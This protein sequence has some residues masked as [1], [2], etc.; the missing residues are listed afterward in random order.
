MD[1]SLIERR[2]ARGNYY[3]T[4]DIFAADVRRMCTNARIY[5]AADT[6]YYKLSL[7]LEEELDHLIKARI[8]LSS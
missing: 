4:L 8:C 7:K 6:V 5:N 3:R 2:I 1:L